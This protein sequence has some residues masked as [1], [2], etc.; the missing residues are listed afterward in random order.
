LDPAAGVAETKGRW[1]TG[2]YPVLPVEMTAERG[3]IAGTG[4]GQLELVESMPFHVFAA[5]KLGAG[6]IR[7]TRRTW[8]GLHRSTR[9]NPVV[10]LG[11]PVEPVE[12]AGA[13]LKHLGLV[14]GLSGLVY[15]AVDCGAKGMQSVHLLNMVTLVLSAL[16]PL[17]TEFPLVEMLRRNA[18]VSD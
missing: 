3:E 8:T 18:A 5:A 11:M 6:V 15:A 9:L 4:S 10:H 12:I 1:L 2:H 7:R 17:A 13:A 16:G 14:G